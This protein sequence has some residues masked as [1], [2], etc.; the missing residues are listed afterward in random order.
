MPTKNL[1]LETIW[2]RRSVRSFDPRPVPREVVETL[3]DA[4]NQA[5]SGSNS[6]PWR[7]VVVESEDARRRLL[8]AAR[9]RYRKWLATQSLA[10][11]AMR[12]ET[13]A[14]SRDSIYY[15]APLVVFVI[16]RGGGSSGFDC[17]LAC[18]NLML[19][20]ASLGVGSCWVHIGSLAVGDPSVQAML[21]LAEGEKVYGPIILGYPQETPPPAPQKKPP[22]TTWL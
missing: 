17:P 11:Q 5:P 18:G 6:Q 15:S 16:G 7:F 2:S 4:A 20:A 10:F 19:A 12:Q 21:G 22:Q 8:E 14:E 3:I 9:P 13:D 1:V